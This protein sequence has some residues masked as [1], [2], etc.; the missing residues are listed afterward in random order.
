MGKTLP[1][2]QRNS[3]LLLTDDFCCDVKIAIIIKPPDQMR[4]KNAHCKVN[5]KDLRWNNMVRSV[6]T[7]SSQYTFGVQY[8]VRLVPSY[9]ERH[10]GRYWFRRL[11]HMFVC[12]HYVNKT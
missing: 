8:V 6:C 1:K 5:R 9:V 11:L 2:L 10:S 12:R 3:Y 4:E 7:I